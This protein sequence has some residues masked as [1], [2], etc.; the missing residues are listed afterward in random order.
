MDSAT[1]DAIRDGMAPRKPTGKGKA[2]RFGGDWT[3]AKLYDSHDL[4]GLDD[5]RAGAVRSE[6]PGE[7]AGQLAPRPHALQVHLESPGASRGA[8]VSSSRSSFQGPP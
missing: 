3:I 5:R 1:R 2:H 6:N 4:V 7:P 8:A